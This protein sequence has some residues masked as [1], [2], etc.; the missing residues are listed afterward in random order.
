M[1]LSFVDTNVL[2]YA[3][4]RGEPEKQKVALALLEAGDADSFVISSQVLGEFFTVVTRKLATPLHHDEAASAVL[5][6]SDLAVVPV[7][8]SLVREALDLL[9]GE[10]V[11][12]WDA[13]IVVAARRG[14]CVRILTEDLR[15]G[16]TVSGI[17]IENPFA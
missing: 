6:L 9:A 12:Y 17:R 1:P 5:A 10:Q 7:D 8:A 14:G 3:Y 15:T 11:S 16:G 4:D 13:L 2:V